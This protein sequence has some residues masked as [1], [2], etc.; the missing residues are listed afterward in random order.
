MESV[1][2]RAQAPV[3]L[4][5]P[6]DSNKNSQLTSEQSNKILS[7]SYLSTISRAKG[8]SRTLTLQLY[9]AAIVG[10]NSTWCSLRP[11]LLASQGHSG[12]GTLRMMLYTL[13]FDS[14]KVG[15]THLYP[16]STDGTVWF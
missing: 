7:Q 5:P 15:H 1:H 4:Q 9:L 14:K 10:S 13:S 16:N 3:T 12:T 8:V 11:T 2:V 6:D